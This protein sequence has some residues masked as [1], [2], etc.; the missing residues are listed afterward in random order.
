MYLHNI[1]GQFMYASTDSHWI[2]VKRIL[3][4]PLLLKVQYFI[5]FILLNAP[6]LLYMDLQIQI[7]LVVLMIASLRV[8]ILSF[9]V[10]RRFLGN[11][12]SNAQLLAPLLRL[13]IKPLQ[14][15]LLK[16][17]GFNTC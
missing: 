2:V 10:R 8:A 16:S 5:V 13:S 14:I 3:H 12:A 4:Y 15:V 1:F 7:G 9:F 11:P 17:F 6:L